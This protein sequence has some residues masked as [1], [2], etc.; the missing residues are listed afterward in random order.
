ML[1]ILANPLSAE[2]AALLA[3]RTR[4]SSFAV[5]A[6]SEATRACT[7]SISSM[8]FSSIAVLL[9]S[10]RSEHFQQFLSA[11]RDIRTG[12]PASYR[13]VRVTPPNIHSRTVEWP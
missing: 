3:A 4:A 10:L 13:T 1:Q 8:T 12:R 2:L 9:R 5:L 6:L 7:A 11:H